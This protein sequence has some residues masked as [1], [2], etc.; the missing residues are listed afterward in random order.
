MIGIEWKF[1]ALLPLF[2]ATCICLK[3]RNQFWDFVNSY[4]QTEVYW[5][6]AFFGAFS[7][8]L[9]KQIAWDIKMSLLSWIFFTPLAYYYLFNGPFGVNCT[10]RP[11]DSDSNV[12]DVTLEENKIAKPVN[13]VYELNILTELGPNTS[14][15]D[16]K[17]SCPAGTSVG[18]VITPKRGH[19]F[20]HEQNIISGRNVS[21]PFVITI[22]LEVGSLSEIRKS[23]EPLAISNLDGGIALESIDL[24]H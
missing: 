12:P 2:I 8:A 23:S 21:D 7:G 4:K 16:F 24:I 22:Y 14:V 13:D 11:V 18:S 10:Y 17:L 3:K 9:P 5:I 20:N 6:T 19:W 15:Y 1:V